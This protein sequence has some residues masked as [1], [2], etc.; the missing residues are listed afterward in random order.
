L[1]HET[2]HVFHDQ[3]RVVDHHPDGQHQPEQGQQIHGESEQVH[4]GEG[5]D[6]CHGNGDHGYQGGAEMLQ[7]QK[8]DSHHQSGGDQQGDQHLP[9]RHFHKFGGVVGNVVFHAFRESGGEILQG[10]EHL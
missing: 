4:A 3:N 10:G 5:A 9:N 8:S 1:V 7:K 6:E 2:F